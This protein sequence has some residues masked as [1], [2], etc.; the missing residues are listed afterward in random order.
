[1]RV[2]M[3]AGVRVC[4]RCNLAL[5]LIT[6]L[7]LDTNLSVDWTVHLPFILHLAVLGQSH[8]HHL[9]Q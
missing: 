4:C 5:M 3:T 1:M 8:Q 7:V 9:N 2:C 6:D